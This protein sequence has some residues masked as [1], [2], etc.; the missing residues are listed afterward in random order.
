MANY[1]TQFFASPAEQI[2]WVT[3][4]CGTKNVWCLW[5]RRSNFQYEQLD[6][7]LLNESHFH[8]L[9][10]HDLFFFVGN[11]NLSEGPQWQ[12]VPGGKR[13][14]DFVRS[15]SVRISA[16]IIARDDV[17]L[18]GNVGIMARIF[19]EEAGIDYI[20]VREWY[21]AVVAPLIATKSRKLKLT[22]QLS[23]RQIKIWRKTSWTI[24]DKSA[25]LLTKSCGP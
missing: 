3:K 6:P 19:Y 11:Y 16:S 2:A 15:Q 22:Q 5:N 13:D 25:L 4:L 12:E 14:I 24:Q 9:S 18:D 10:R 1:Q 20:G 23:S 21:K 8:G 17:L 7:H